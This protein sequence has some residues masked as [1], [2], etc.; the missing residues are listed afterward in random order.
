MRSCQRRDVGEACSSQEKSHT[1]RP[2]SGGSPEQSTARPESK[3]EASPAGP[4]WVLVRPDGSCTKN[5]GKWL[6]FKQEGVT[7][8]SF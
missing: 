6:S 8:I 1:L 4:A 7:R 2:E 5:S 3:L